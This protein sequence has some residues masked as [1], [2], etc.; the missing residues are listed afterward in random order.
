MLIIAGLLGNISPAISDRN[1]DILK[2]KQCKQK[3]PL[4]ILKSGSKMSFRKKRA[5]SP[6]DVPSGVY[7]GLCLFIDTEGPSII[8]RAICSGIFISERYIVTT[9]TPMIDRDITKTVAVTNTILKQ[10]LGDTN[11]IYLKSFHPKIS[12]NNGKFPSLVMQKP[13]L[14]FYFDNLAHQ[15]M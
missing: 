3:T 2:A 8:D 13:K 6:K 9:R 4:D 11:K 14:A 15:Q 5:P 10:G 7:K 1:L 12:E